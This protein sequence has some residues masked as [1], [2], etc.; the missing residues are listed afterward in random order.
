MKHYKP[1]V[2]LDLRKHFVS[3]RVIEHWNQ[4][5]QHIVDTPSV[6]SFKNRLDRHW[7]LQLDLDTDI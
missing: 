6:N 2:R 4:F 1:D 7:K 5:P 3:Y